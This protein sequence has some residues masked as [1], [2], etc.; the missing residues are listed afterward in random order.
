MPRK[1]KFSY[2]ILVEKTKCKKSLGR[3]KIKGGTALQRVGLHK[4]PGS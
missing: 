1:Y 4:R 3:S 2:S